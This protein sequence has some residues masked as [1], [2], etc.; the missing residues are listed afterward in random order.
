V[1]CNHDCYIF[2]VAKVVHENVVSALASRQSLQETLD[3][4]CKTTH[5]VSNPKKDKQVCQFLETLFSSVFPGCKA[6]PFGSRMSGLAL[7]DSDLDIFLDTGS[8]SFAACK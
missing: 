8:S 1:G 6:I 4:L 3:A 7:S 5:C 2:T